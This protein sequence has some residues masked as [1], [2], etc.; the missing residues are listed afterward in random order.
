MIETSVAILADLGEKYVLGHALISL[1]VVGVGRGEFEAAR[2]RLA[3]GLAI[4]Q[5]LDHPWGM[6]D[7]LTNLGCIYRIVGEY[8]TAQSYL[9]QA[10]QVYQEH[11]RSMWETDVRC[12]LAENAIAQGD[13]PAAR[14]HLHVAPDP[15]QPAENKW[16]Q[17]LVCYFRGLL[18]YYEGDL[19]AAVAFLTETAALAREGTF[20]PDLARALVTLGR[21]RRTLGQVSPA[22]ELLLEGLAL[23]RALGHRLGIAEGLEELGALSAVQGDGA[24][25]ALLFGAAHALREQIGAPLPPVDRPAHDAVVAA[26]RAQLGETAFAEAWALAAAR[27]WQDV[28]DQGLNAA[29]VAIA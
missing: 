21:V 16:L 9:E 29:R 8:S 13:L 3:R 28:V 19:A 2:A 22:S 25:A 7:A 1:G 24:Q 10:L 20:K 12:A 17:T 26:A 6:A 27:P 18:A 5:E 4:A 23:F 14:F 15:V 11:G